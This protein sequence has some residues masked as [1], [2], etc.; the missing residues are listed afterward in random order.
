MKQF[1]KDVTI[2]D[3]YTPA[4]GIDNQAEADQYFETCV[5]HTMTFG[6]TREEAVK[7][8]RQNL[9]Y[10]AGYYDEATRERVGRLF[11]CSRP[12]FGS[13]SKGS[14]TPEEALEAGKKWASK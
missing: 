3:K 11:K 8:E 4:M 13:I 10:Y 5:E 9:G 1:D 2:G 14:P 6:K 12:I 7:I